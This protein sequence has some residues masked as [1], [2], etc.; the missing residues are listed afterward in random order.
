MM[1]AYDYAV[2]LCEDD[3]G[4][5]TAILLDA[6]DAGIVVAPDAEAALAQLRT[7]VDQRVGKGELGAPDFL[8]PVL[9]SFDIELWPQYRHR[10][11]DL[12]LEPVTIA[13][14]CV[15]G[16]DCNHALVCAL[17]TLGQ[18]FSFAGTDTLKR[19]VT[20]RVQAEL[21][22]LTPNALSRRLPPPRVWLGE[23]SARVGTRERAQVPFVPEELSRIAEPVCAKSWPRQLM[24]PIGRDKEADDVAGRLREGNANILLVGEA[25]EGKTSVL[26]EAARKAESAPQR[27]ARDDDLDGAPPETSRLWRTNAARIVAGMKWLGEWEE[28][29]EK[30]VRELA[31]FDGILCI[32]NLLDLVRRGGGDPIA[33]IAA[34]FLNFMQHGELRMIAEATPQEVDACRRL[35]PGLIDL[36][37]VVTIAPFSAAEAVRAL[38]TIGEA[39]AKRLGLTVEPE[40]PH[41]V[42]ALF[43]RFL[44]YQALPCKAAEF[45]RRLCER[46]AEKGGDAVGRDLVVAEFA[47]ETGLAETFLRD[48][49]PL[50]EAEVEAHFRSRVI[51]QDRACAAA[52]KIVSV[53]KTGLNDPK[54]PVAV[55]LFCGP[56]GVGKTQLA[57]T[58]ARFLYGGA[59]E[60]ERMVRLDMSEYAGFDAATRLLDDQGSA[61]IRKVREQPFTVV[62]LDEIE[63]AAHEVHDVLLGVLDEGRLTDTWG[64]TTIF[65]S[66]VIIMTSNLGA[67]R[68]DSIGF[69]AQPAVPYDDEVMAFF[70]PE[71][72]NRLDA[73][74]TFDPLGPEVVREITRKELNELRGREG[75]A[76][77]GIGLQWTDAL[78]AHLVQHGFDRRYG[79]R[80]LQRAIESLVVAPLA[81]YLVEH[82]AA[83]D[84]ELLIDVASDGRVV[85]APGGGRVLP[86]ASPERGE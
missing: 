64:R 70:R 9:A 24:R 85:I 14:P 76:R 63:K 19:L 44:P 72:Y 27:G 77:A 56:T 71:F 48:T 21:N 80:P 52:A 75:L 36:F 30:I 29:C 3:A 38:A 86:A 49:I 65:R 60:G 40:V 35:L 15:L 28:R 79:A 43:R 8:A 22:G 18:T 41:A 62:L 20:H 46:I 57:K 4:F 55:L 67:Q 31:L 66:A 74:V 1:H 45:V 59:T 39:A 33:S 34:L 84:Y 2:F 51:G 69:G 47:R 10:G 73:V 17:P 13:F 53:F 78:V 5:V 12:P 37:Q 58:I 23:V 25:G 54:R 82:P 16:R 81:R 26:Y 6:I 42:H 50:V 32:E 7:Y 83:A 61:L 68:C 11:R